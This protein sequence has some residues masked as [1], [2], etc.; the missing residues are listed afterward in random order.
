VESPVE[1]CRAALVLE[2]GLAPTGQTIRRRKKF[3]LQNRELRP[4]SIHHNE[5]LV[6]HI[7]SLLA[8]LYDEHKCRPYHK[9]YVDRRPS[10]TGLLISSKFY[11]S[12]RP[13]HGALL[14]AP[15]DRD[16]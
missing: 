4:A 7:R 14:T 6:S 13:T 15:Q 9:L 8:L 10:Q 12:I 16:L 1:S 3:P 11:P 2:L 5:L